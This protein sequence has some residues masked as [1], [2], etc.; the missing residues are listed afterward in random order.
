MYVFVFVATSKLPVL[1][2]INCTIQFSK[3]SLGRIDQV[4]RSWN[5]KF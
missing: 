5:A 4:K 2:T 1:C 3:N